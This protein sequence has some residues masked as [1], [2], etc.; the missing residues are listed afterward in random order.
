MFCTGGIRCEKSTSYLR[1]LGFEEVYH[2]EGGILKYLEKIPKKESALLQSRTEGPQRKTPLKLLTRPWNS[3]W[4]TSHAP[5]PISD[6]SY[7]P[8]IRTKSR[9]R[10]L[11]RCLTESHKQSLSTRSNSKSERHP[12]MPRLCY[13]ASFALVL[14][15]T[16]LQAMVLQSTGWHQFEIVDDHD[17]WAL[18][19]RL[20]T[21]TEHTLRS[22]TSCHS[23][24][25]LQ[26]I[27]L[28]VVAYFVRISFFPGPTQKQRTDFHLSLSQDDL[29][30]YV[31]CL[32]YT[33]DA[34]DE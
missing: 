15:S 7:W 3:C 32:L 27:R 33:S 13:R 19:P 34:A 5:K 17:L 6:A 1:S 18:V 21:D 16:V 30:P 14:Q 4:R 10:S 24:V 22:I 2:L 23:C 28:Q 25:V 8:C 26:S 29:R 9:T 12:A 31:G 11:N 20:R